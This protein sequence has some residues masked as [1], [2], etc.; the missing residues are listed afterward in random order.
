MVAVGTL[1]PDAPSDQMVQTFAGQNPIVQ[2]H[3]GLGLAESVAEQLRR[4][5][6]QNSIGTQ[7]VAGGMDG[8]YFILHFRQSLDE[9]CRLKRCFYTHD[10]AHRFMLADNDVK[11]PYKVGETTFHPHPCLA[12]CISVITGGDYDNLM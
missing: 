2:E 7:V 12:E 11:K 6:P 3:G 1:N 8:Q 10:P 4:I 9:M 5:M